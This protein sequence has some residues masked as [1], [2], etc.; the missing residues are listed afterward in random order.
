[1]FNPQ[2]AEQSNNTEDEVEYLEDLGVVFFDECNNITE[3]A[4]FIKYSTIFLI[5]VIIGI[6]SG[7]Y[8]PRQFYTL[9]DF[10]LDSYGVC[11][12]TY[13]S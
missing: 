12:E 1:M 13:R 11:L 6:I 10:K 8:I 4:I 9:E 5:I 2:D 7:I 3:I